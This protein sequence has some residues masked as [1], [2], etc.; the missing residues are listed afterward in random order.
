MSDTATAEKIGELKGEVRSLVDQMD[1]VVGDVGD[2]KETT[3]RIEGM[4]KGITGSGP[5]P[6][7]ATQRQ[8]PIEPKHE[9]ASIGR[10]FSKHG[11]HIVYVT[12]LVVLGIALIAA[13]YD[14]NASS[15][16]LPIPG[17]ANTST[18]GKDKAE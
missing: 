10:F 2:L 12:G 14:R 11:T 1:R 9:T 3:G 6:T 4:L 7:P 18:S 15:L 8:E 5:H 16:V 17:T 13:I